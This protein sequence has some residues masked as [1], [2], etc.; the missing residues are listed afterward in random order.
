MLQPSVQGGPA[1]ASGAAAAGAGAG[2]AAAAIASGRGPG[3]GVAAAEARYEEVKRLGD[4]LS[5]L[6]GALAVQ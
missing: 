1:A 2:A 5:V 6:L 3:G 4:Q